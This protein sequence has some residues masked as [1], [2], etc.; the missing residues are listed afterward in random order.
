MPPQTD[1]FPDPNAAL[2]VAFDAGMY[3]A[4]GKRGRAGLKAKTCF[5]AIENGE[6]TST[7]RFESDS[8]AQFK[9]WAALKPGDRVR[10]WSGK[11][12]QAQGAFTGRS[13]I[14]EVTHAPGRIRLERISPEGAARWEATEGWSRD[15]IYTF[16]RRGYAEA[17]YIRYRLV[18]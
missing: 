17:L 11:W 8:P 10:V 18:S 5:E 6:R 3:Y 16:I 13:L 4:Y 9:K 7:T 12:D 1:L 2:P 15:E 14:V